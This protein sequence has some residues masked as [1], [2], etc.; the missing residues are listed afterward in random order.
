MTEFLSIGQRIRIRLFLEGIEIPV[1]SA[2]VVAAP[3]SPS[4]CTL[5]VPPLVE[6]TRLLPR[7]IVHLFFHDAWT[8]SNPYLLDSDLHGTAPS[9]D[10]SAV[11][12]DEIEAQDAGPQG[13][14]S[15]RGT[16]GAPDA[17]P[18][19]ITAVPCGLSGNN[20]WQNRRF[21][22]LFTGEI[23]G[24]SWTKSPMSRSLVLQCEDFSNYWDYAYQWSNTGIFGPGQKAIFSGGAT[25]LFTDFLSSQGSM[26]T[27]IILQGKCNTFPRL[28][29]LAAGIVRLIEAIGGSYYSRSKDSKGNSPRK[30]AG[31]NIFFSLAELRLHITQMIAVYEDDPTSK[32]LL[33]RHG[34]DGMFNRALGG[35]GQQVSI[36][37]AISA[38][39]RIMFHETYPQPCPYY[40][41]SKGSEPT[42]TR[43]VKIKN[44]K[45]YKPFADQAAASIHALDRIRQALE[46][47]RTNEQF[48]SQFE[49]I[50]NLMREYQTVVA[51]NRDELRKALP[52]MRAVDAPDLLVSIFTQAARSLNQVWSQIA[53]WRPADNQNLFRQR[54]VQPKL[55]EALTQLRR[56]PELSIN[57]IPLK[58]LEPARLVQ[59]ILRPDI[60][61]GAPPRCNVLFPDTY[62]QLSYRRMFLQE[63][64]RF[65]LKTNDEF[66]G[67][68]FLFDRF[69]F[70]PQ[71]RSLKG[72][73]ADLRSVLKNDLLDH[74]LF[75]GI[76]PVFEKMGEFNVF[77]ARSN[78]EQQGKVVKVSF[79]QRSANFL[80]FKHRFNAR[81][82]QISG[83]FNPYI[84]V[85]FPGLIIDRWVDREATASVR[86]L[87]EQFIASDEQTRRLLLPKYTAELIGT[88]FLAN[89]TEVTHQVS[90]EQ[91]RGTTSVRCT[92]ARQPSEGIEFLGVTEGVQ[93]VQRRQDG[94]ALRTTDVAAI[95]PPS[96][97][98]LGPNQGRIVN[99]RDVTDKYAR[100]AQPTELGVPSISS[101][102]AGKRLP[103]FLSDT[104]REG[105]T[106][107][108]NVVV[109]IG[110]PITPADLGPD[111][112]RRLIEY[113][114]G[115]GL[116]PDEVVDASQQR[117]VFRAY[118][119]D[120][121]VP[122]YKLEEVDWPV[123][124]LI[125]PGWYG[126][127]W[128]PGKIQVVYKDFFGIGSITEAIA[129][130]DSRGGS[131]GDA[132]ENFRRAIEEQQTAECGEDAHADVP[133]V[134]SLAENSSI[135][136]AVEFLTLTYS[137]VKQANLDVDEFIRAYTWRP[138][139]SMV[140]MFGTDGLTFNARGTDVTSPGEI[141]GFHS[142]AFGPYDDVFGLVG[143]ELET[144]V[145]IKRG[146]T[147]AQRGDTRKRKF[148][149]VSAF[150]AALNFSRAQLG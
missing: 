125:R 114:S 3:N 35:L 132:N 2:Q 93:T 64:T 130:L 58:E 32:R 1:I 4:M 34:Y 126:D 18:P 127:V 53:N 89:F 129:V 88:N 92:Y 63:P 54:V 95:G 61:F 33:S 5:Q 102:T 75:T 77:A 39:T 41:P 8:T 100:T 9:G 28:E 117:V 25:S 22:V 122:R 79:A 144:V 103:V 78:R 133:V 40:K 51:A 67:E 101:D 16:S 13:G 111:A 15:G 17:P 31:Q 97:F 112:G 69:Y 90:Q 145:G 46:G 108:S 26:L 120:E 118:A 96:L 21:K 44:D 30:F 68:D 73:K 6:G 52:E 139:A 150:L 65:M 45:R 87:R 76:L 104:R 91:L 147:V 14:G 62:E 110:R 124:E 43:R 136:Q 48:R 119:I 94:D 60:W 106:D 10:P 81:Q 121:E 12:I 115:T 86:K 49:S 107:L 23:V 148:E 140:D 82:F 83:R 123:E 37:K 72:Q 55:E 85:G 143:P 74:E 42:G 38:I 70:S 66:F 80:Y 116:T 98:S 29:G 56:V 11:N 84:A 20:G 109:P 7:T 135:E 59:Q 131:V 27:S 47:L 142:R 99:R 57:T 128:S 149:Q 71:V 36:R 50:P 105:G 24:F 137:Y 113:L 19:T 134:T 138:I 146:S 141:E